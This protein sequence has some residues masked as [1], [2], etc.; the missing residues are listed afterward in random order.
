MH[1][2]KW[3]NTKKTI[4]RKAFDL[5]LK[6]ELDAVIRDVKSR[7][8]RIEKPQDLWK[9]ESYLTECRKEIDFKYDYRY[10]VLPVVFARLL[11]DG[12]LTED[13]LQGLGEDKFKWIRGMAIL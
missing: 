6:K 9:L 5:A 2:L 3:S 13:D 12:L 7:A 1:D 8:A 10:S 11:R 4:A